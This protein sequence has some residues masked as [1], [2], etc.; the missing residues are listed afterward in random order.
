MEGHLL[1]SQKDRERLKIFERVKRGELQPVEA[2]EICGLS[3]RET[4]RQY[5]R[6]REFGGRGLVHRRGRPSNRSY[7]NEFRSAVLA[8][9]YEE[10]YP[11]FGPTLAAEKRRQDGYELDHETLRQWLMRKKL[12]RQ[13]RKRAQHRSWRERRRHFGELVQMD[14]SHHEWF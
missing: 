8:A 2:A 6:F 10:R 12:W 13:R 9:R 7:A 4:R 3:C 11:D 14:E 1:M 5:Q